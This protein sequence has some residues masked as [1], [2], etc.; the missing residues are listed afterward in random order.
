MPRKYT[1]HRKTKQ[2]K[3]RKQKPPSLDKM[4]CSPL[5]EGNTANTDTCYPPA[6]LM[7]IRDAYNA[8]H[9]EQMIQEN[10]PN[11]V[12][13][14]L[15]ERLSNCD[16]ED[17]WLKEIKDTQMQRDLDA[18]VFAPDRPP[19]WTNSPNEWLSNFDIL[20]ILRQYEKKHRDFKMIGP[21]PIDFDTRPPEDG[22]KCVWQELCTFDLANYIQRGIRQF[23]IVF[24]LDTHDKNGSHWVSLFI[25]AAPKRAFAFFFDSAG[26]PPPKE[27]VSLVEKIQGQWG[28]MDSTPMSFIQNAPH[29]HQYGNTECGMY[30]LI[31]IVTMLTGKPV[32]RAMKGGILS[33]DQRMRIFLKGKITDKEAA[34]YRRIYFNAP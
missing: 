2:R 4:N 15:K 17:C 19:S 27:V 16:K 3:T 28:Q 33:L 20:A 6:V 30:S 8:K 7:Q 32:K 10:R 11:T 21:T 18:I 13:R 26:S 9:P 5:V 1:H 23:G 29:T 22:G 31:F 12:W 24:N 14:I 25:C 34:E